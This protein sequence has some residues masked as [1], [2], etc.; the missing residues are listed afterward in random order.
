MYN[1]Y[2]EYN[3]EYDDTFLVTMESVF[4]DIDF[5]ALEAENDPDQVDENNSEPAKKNIDNIKEK[6]KAIFDT[7]IR[8]V[9]ELFDSIALGF[10]RFMLTNNGFLKEFAQWKKMYK[11]EPTI[12]VINFEYGENNVRYLENLNKIAYGFTDTIY[13]TYRNKANSLDDIQDSDNILNFDE[14]QFV[15]EWIKKLGGNTDNMGEF[16]RFVKEKFRGEKKTLKISSNMI[17]YYEQVLKSYTNLITESNT[18]MAKMKSN[19]NS[20]QSYI[21]NILSNSNCTQEI[22]VKLMKQTRNLTKAIA[23]NVQFIHYM[24]DLKIEYAVN[25]RIILSRFYN[26]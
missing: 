18:T 3:L 25:S 14:K 5:L 23:L 7:I 2:Y 20:A 13:K 22:R 11:P 19:I 16:L 8:V 9:K 12:E 26:R 1:K 15:E 6:I 24:I 10:K 21:S 4:C 17:T